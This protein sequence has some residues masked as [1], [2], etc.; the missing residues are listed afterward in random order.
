MKRKT[1]IIMGL[2]VASTVSINTAL[3]KNGSDDAPGDNRCSHP[4]STPK[5]ENKSKENKGKDNVITALLTGASTASGNASL[6]VKKNDKEQRFKIN[7]KIPVGNTSP[8]YNSKQDAKN[9]IITAL[10]SRNSTPYAK[11]SLSL[12]RDSYSRGAS[13]RR[14]E[15]KVD[16]KFENNKVLRGSKSKC[17]IDLITDG[18][19]KGIPSP[20]V[21]DTIVINEAVAGDFL[22]G[23]F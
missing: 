21:G 19:Q 23:Q 18:I 15:F 7:V 6:R 9:M 17:D 12:D 10:L 4:V 13:L 20:I 5:S 8:A 2:L 16:V 14:A 11:C 1:M 22:Q 3:A